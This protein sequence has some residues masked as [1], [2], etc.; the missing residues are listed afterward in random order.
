M[1]KYPTLLVGGVLLAVAPLTLSSF[2]L[3]LLAQ[4]AVLAVFAASYD[5]LLGYT[6]IFSFGH[7]LFLGV[8]AY[9]AALFLLNG[10]SLP[11]AMLAAVSA[12]AVLAVVI[13]A[14]TL[15]SKGVYYAMITLAFAEMFHIYAGMA[16]VTGGANG[17]IGIPLPSFIAAPVGDYYVMVIFAVICFGAMYFFLDSPTGRVLR[18][19]RDNPTRA[20]MIGYN[21]PLYLVIAQVVAA[22]F[23]A[24][25]GVFLALNQGMVYTNVLSSNTTVN[26]L[27]IV[28]LGGIGTLFGA[29]AG[30][31]IVVVAGSI[32]ANYFP[33]WPLILGALYIIVVLLYPQGLMQLSFKR[34]GTIFRSNPAK[35]PNVSAGSDEGS[36]FH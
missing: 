21:V 14:V 32:L 29:V 4:A 30:S 18:A 10:H 3:S 28:V 6:G 34:L 27:L 25:A 33:Y 36:D 16:K 5:L 12:A 26:A 15:R 11:L 20:A 17:L 23:A 1:R 13:G 9:L 24:L 2:V 19:V 22:V 35:E 8:G 7:A 31:L